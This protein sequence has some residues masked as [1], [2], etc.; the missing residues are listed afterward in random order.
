QYCAAEDF[1]HTYKMKGENGS[2]IFETHVNR[3]SRTQ[4]NYSATTQDLCLDRNGLPVQRL[5]EDH[6]GIASWE[7]LENVSCTAGNNISQELNK[8]HEDLVS[9]RQSQEVILTQV[10]QVSKAVA[11]LKPVDVYN[12]ASIFGLID[13][14]KQNSTVFGANLINICH[15]IMQMNATVLRLSSRLNATNALLDNFEK[16]MDALSE[17]LVRK[18]NCGKVISEAAS[19]SAA[20]GVQLINNADIGVQALISSNLSVFYVNPRC[21]SITGMA[22]Y[23]AERSDRKL[24]GHFWYRY[25][26]ANESVEALMREPDLETAAYLPGD[27]WTIELQKRASYFVLKVYDNDALFVDA[28]LQSRPRPKVKVLSITIPGFDDELPAL[29]NFLLRKPNQVG[30]VCAY[31]SYETWQLRGIMTSSNMFDDIV[32]CQ[33]SHLTQFSA[34]F[35]ED[36]WPYPHNKILSIGTDVGCGLSL[37]GILGIFLT[38]LLVSKWRELASTKVLLHLCLALSLQLTLFVILTRMHWSTEENW[39]RCWIS[40]AALQYSVLLIFSWMLIIALLQFHRYVTVLGV[41]R[42]HHFVLISAIV[43]WSLPLLPTLLVVFFAK[44]SYKATKNA[45]CYPSGIGLLLGIV[46]PIVLVIVANAFMMIRIVYSVNQVLSPR[47]KL[48][49]QQL[50]LFVLLF[51]LLGISWVFGIGTYLK[52]GIIYSY[53]FCLTAPLQGIVLF[54]Y[55]VLFNATHRR[56]WLRFICPTLVRE[57][58]PRSKTQVQST[59]F[60]TSSAK[61]TSLK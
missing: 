40:G 4:M 36:D 27:L 45:F 11:Q 48:I 51:F 55:F 35:G 34:L 43:A 28:S 15:N 3:F 21:S 1:K 18:E 41:N 13:A 59:S 49:F 22:I 23:S 14:S 9:G 16:N 60:S 33:A 5:C 29:V 37:C 24:I 20:A 50:R 2:L 17:H 56:A 12:T 47:R 46:L 57:D 38:A 42:P 54:F 8:L 30:V 39:T 10:E 31:W 44:K 7:Q 52:Q 32:L 61:K 58:V 19:E 26:Y 6:N 53:L 25:L